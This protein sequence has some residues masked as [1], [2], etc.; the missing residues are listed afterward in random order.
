MKPQHNDRILQIDMTEFYKLTFCAIF[1]SLNQTRT[2]LKITQSRP[3]IE[4][5]SFSL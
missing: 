4:A 1:L 5:R 2:N 3:Q